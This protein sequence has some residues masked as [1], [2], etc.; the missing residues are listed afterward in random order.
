MITEVTLPAI[1]VE[2]ELAARPAIT[3]SS[4]A[5]LQRKRPSEMAAAI[6]TRWLIENGDAA[7]AEASILRDEEHRQELLLLERLSAV[8]AA[9]SRR[10]TIAR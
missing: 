9:R 1:R 2:A 6:L 8:Q 10:P 5:R 3:L 7:I 4:L